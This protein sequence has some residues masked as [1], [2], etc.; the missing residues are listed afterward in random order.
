MK[1]FLSHY[2]EPQKGDVLNDVGEVIGVHDG[3]VFYALGERHGF[4]ITKKTS[5]NERQYVVSKDIKANTITVSN[6]SKK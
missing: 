5:N 1:D 6:K 4:T 2:I 3:A